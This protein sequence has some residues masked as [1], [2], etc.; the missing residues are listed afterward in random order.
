MAGF[1]KVNLSVVGAANGAPVPAPGTTAAA[2]VTLHTAPPA[3]AGIDEMWL[4]AFGGLYGAAVTHVLTV[5]YNGISIPMN[6]YGQ[7]GPIN[8]IPGWLLSG[9]AT[10]QIWA[11]TTNAI[12][13]DGYVNRILQ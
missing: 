11:D 3:N 12:W 8:L 6:I 2:A 13:V 1:L 10:V 7:S 4:W 9:A 5:I